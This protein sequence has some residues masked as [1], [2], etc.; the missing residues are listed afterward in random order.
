MDSKELSAYKFPKKM[1]VCQDCGTKSDN[2]TALQ[3]HLGC[4]GYIVSTKLVVRERY[5]AKTADTGE[6]VWVRK[7]DLKGG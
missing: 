2:H 5:E 3:W 6:V 7:G 1:F 4:V